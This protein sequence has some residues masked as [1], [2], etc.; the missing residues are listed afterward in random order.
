MKFLHGPVAA[1]EC[2]VCH[3][4]HGSDYKN[5][6]TDDPNELC[7]SCHEVTEN[8]LQKFQFVH[9]PM[10]G[11]CDGC[12]D[13]HGANNV[14]M[15]IDEPPKLC[16]PCHEDIKKMTETAKYQH[17]AVTEEDGCMHC[18]TPHASTVKHGLKAPPIEL[19]LACHDKPVGTSEDEVLGAF[20]AE[21]E[22]KEFLHGPIAEKDCEGCHTSHGSEH[23]RL[24]AKEY[25]PQFYAPFSKENYDLCF[26]C[27]PES[28]VLTRETS[29]LTDFRNGELNLHYL[30][31]NKPRR[32]RTCRSCHATHA[33]NLPRHI[34]QS[35]PYGRWDLPIQFEK[36]ETG[37]SCQPGCHLPFAY[38]RQTPVI[39]KRPQ[40]I[41]VKLN[42][43]SE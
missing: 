10:K 30:H 11:K 16:Y 37:G 31:V 36:T 18:H 41:S 35:V 17:S 21:L 42:S 8:E 2:T 38:D 6:L 5:L 14:M 20:T 40:P 25:P 9:E 34:R 27:H 23:F 4:S 43:K 26:S 24:L 32:G 19:C 1:G 39:Y 28:I 3:D 15:L 22:N 13:A 12:H 29:D 33:S 7:F